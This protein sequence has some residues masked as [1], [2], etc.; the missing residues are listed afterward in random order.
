MLKVD[1]FEKMTIGGVDQWVRIRSRDPQLPVLLILYGGP[2]VPLFPRIDDF[3]ER[4]GLEETFT[5][6]YWEQRG[7]GKSY[8][9][10]I[11]T[12]SMTI[13][14]FVQD[15]FELTDRLRTRFGKEKIFLLGESWGTVIGLRAAARCPARFHAYVGTGQVVDMLEGDRA[16]YAFTLEEAERRGHEKAL[17]ELDALGP[18]PYTPKEV[19]TQRKWVGRFGG[20]RHDTKP[21]S[22]LG[23]LLELATTP[24]YSWRDVWQIAMNPFFALEELLDELYAIDFF[25]EIPR[26]ELPVYLLEGRYDYT[27]PPSVTREYYEELEAPH[28]EWIWFDESAHFTFLEEPDRFRRAMQQVARKAQPASRQS[29]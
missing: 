22:V 16:S 14:R 3:G 9:P 19:M 7:T 13:D 26:V 15:I 8:N 29:R 21:Q 24:E 20:A 10:S 25:K 17:R 18:P 5:V 6:A 28:K 4:A 2:G 11:P 27:T 23:A 12:D 1:A